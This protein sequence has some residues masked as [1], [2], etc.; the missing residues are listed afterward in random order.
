MPFDPSK[1]FKVVNSGFD[2]SKPFKIVEESSK[3][4]EGNKS[5]SEFKNNFVDNAISLIKGGMELQSYASPSLQLMKIAQGENPYSKERY[6]VLYQGIKNIPSTV[7]NDTKEELKHPIESMYNKPISTILDLS[8]VGSL[9]LGAARIGA[10]LTSAASKKLLPGMAKTMAGIPEIATESVLKK[11]SI[12]ST[13]AISEEKLTESVGQPIIQAIKESKIKI[14]NELGEKYRELANMEGPMQEIVNTPIA[15]KISI[16]DN[17]VNIPT[18]KIV[19]EPNFIGGYTEK[20]ITENIPGIKKEIVP[21]VL[22][23]VKKL[24]ISEDKLLIN[25]N[26]ANE[27]FLKGDKDS[28]ISLY[29]TYV[30]NTKSKIDPSKIT[31]S[32]KLQ[33]LTRL[34]REA[35]SLAEYN[36]APV[37]LK[38]IDSAKDA[39]FKKISSDIDS[40]RNKLPNGEILS[41]V[42][43]AYKSINDIY[44][45]IQRD[46]SD[47]GKAKDTMMRLLRG[48][49]TWLTSGKMEIKVNAIKKV[50]KILD[51][52]ILEPALEELTRQVF[53]Q[54][55]GK[56]FVPQIVR[57]LSSGGAG[58]ALM[59]G[60]LPAAIAGGIGLASSS[61]KVIGTAIRTGA[62]IGEGVSSLMPY[63][64]TGAV[65]G[66][67][68]LNK[69]GFKKK[70]K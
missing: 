40:L 11:P 50:E 16:R 62:K 65:M 43:S 52:K 23:T 56:G 44:D 21:G 63:A 37:T 28:L 22:S 48:D 26:L 3:K 66:T 67:V 55:L 46:L 61:P 58:A 9:G 17:K 7:Y 45:T 39:A 64:N 53:N 59:T 30:G 47:P 8:G 32:D 15:Q 38:P 35:Q 10:K 1:P 68:G 6:K 42:D 49:N 60:N 12:L 24:P 29:K 4:V 20:K 70:K 57:S 27:A 31:N 33:I 51:R 34:K 25:K 2:P 36:K 13:P 14:Q 54:N 69:M 41:D 5:I 18:E 19:K